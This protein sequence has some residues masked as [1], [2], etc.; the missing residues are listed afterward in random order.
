MASVRSQEEALGYKYD[1]GRGTA[2]DIPDNGILL[3]N[4]IH[5]AD[6][7]MSHITHL[8]HLSALDFIDTS[9][10]PGQAPWIPSITAGGPLDGA[11]GTGSA[12]V[13]HYVEALEM[14]RKAHVMGAIFNAKHPCGASPVAG[15]TTEI[16]T[17]AK[18][19]QFASLLDEVR[20]FI[21]AKYIPDVATVAGAYKDYWGVGRGSLNLL[22]YGD[23][24]CPASTYKR[25]LSRG[26][27][28][29]GLA[30]LRSVDQTQIREYVNYSYYK[31]ST[32]GMHPSVGATEPD[33]LKVGGGTAYSWLKAPRYLASGGERLTIFPSTTYSA[34]TPIPC[35]V[36]PLARMVATYLDITT[37]PG[38]AITVSQAT[39][40]DSSV[41]VTPINTAIMNR[42]TYNAKQLIDDTVAYYNS[43][44]DPDIGLT[45]LFSPLGRHLARALECKLIADAMGSDIGWLSQLVVG[46]P[47]YTHV[48]LP[49]L[50]AS[51]VGLVE[52][53]RGAL[54]HWIH[55]ESKKIFNYQC[56]VPTTWNAAP[57]ADNGVNGPAE[58]TLIGLDLDA[59]P[60]TDGDPKRLVNILRTL[61]PFD[62][63]IACAVHLIN[64]DGKE[65]AKVA[66]D[67]NGNMT[68]YVI[69][70]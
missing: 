6:T 11:T 50:G 26:R 52:A 33:M 9:G 59:G 45:D 30:T 35:E 5:G 63:C 65:V 17:T 40:T 60:G 51:G 70:E 58:L 62:F 18:K 4:L 8:Y 2:K 47:S 37:T 42:T 41:S 39:T 10:F 22:S 13:A 1:T 27:S 14:R 3:R 61:H 64:A 44:N 48:A 20:N 15:G 54:G 68:E 23:F 24:P 56:V 31:D 38:N 57:K 69:N 34:G 36:G 19:T 32:T 67:P 55:I 66:F 16:A 28:D 25:L 7:V 43:A 21:N 29:Y 12:L 53:P 46:Q 49:T